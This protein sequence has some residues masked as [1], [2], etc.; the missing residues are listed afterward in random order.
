MPKMFFWAILAL[1]SFWK[2]YV[3]FDLDLCFDE[4]YYYYWSLFPQLSYFDHPPL[5]A[6]AMWLSGILHFPGKLVVRIWPLV[7]GIAL[8]F[9]GR[10]LASRIYDR[11]AGDMAGIFLL[12]S[13]VFI[14]NGFL[15][16]PDTLFAPLWA[17]AVSATWLALH[18]DSAGRKGVSGWWFVVG[19]VSG[20]GF[21]CKYNMVIFFL[22]LGFLFL[23]ASH[24]RKQIIWGS[25]ISAIIAFVIFLP[26]LIWNADN[27]WI[28]FR[29]QL[30][31]GFSASRH[32][33][34]KT[35]GNYVGG[36]LILVT[37]I[38]SLLCFRVS[39]PAL[40]SKDERQ[41]FLASFFWPMIAFFGYSAIKTW[42][43][44]NW[45]MMAFFAGLIIL[46][47]S[48]HSV[49][50]SIR[51]VAFGSLLIIDFVVM[52][53]F[54]IPQDV[55][56]V[57][58]GWPIESTRMREFRGA[59]AIA[60]TVRKAQ[61]ET[62]VKAIMAKSHQL[63]G[64]LAFYAPDLRDLLVSSWDCMQGKRP[65]F[66]WIEDEKWGGQDVLMV[67]FGVWADTDMSAFEKVDFLK[68]VNV[69]YRPN[70]FNEVY[71]YM[72]HNFRP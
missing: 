10:S 55:P 33:V 45:P 4:G 28:S 13:P 51:R 16:T 58:A 36:L 70:L 24:W 48:W 60:D 57:V 29:F 8:A 23:L 37:P 47:G 14:A 22:C 69:P 7:S 63:F 11:R 12:L 56:I 53:Y 71:L 65:R 3:A 34:F 25:L 66:P 35:I 2:I 38:V 68:Q 27:D 5:T 43:Q 1:S 19:L 54:V 40:F 15:M 17:L 21:L 39:W 46:A 64:L 20:V 49:L 41:I 31:H 61:Q 67:N 32:S 30:S 44:P 50:P 6:W 42:V 18:N 62:G 72:G 26:V 59:E 52:S 9:I